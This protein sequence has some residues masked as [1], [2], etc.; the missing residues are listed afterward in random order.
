MAPVAT[1]TAEIS[2]AAPGVESKKVAGINAAADPPSAYTKDTAILHRTPFQ[3][4]TAVSAEGLYF[5][6]ADGTRIIDAVG[7]AAVT[8]IGNGNPVVKQAIKDQVEKLSPVP[9]M[10]RSNEP[11]E[12]LAKLL[13]EYAPGAFEQ[14]AFVAGGSEAMEAVIKLA[15]QYFWETKQ[16]QRTKFISRQ[17][18]YH[19]NTLGALSLSGHPGRRKVFEGILN[20]DS[21][22]HVSP[23]YAARFKTPGETDEEYVARLAKE[24]EDKF[25]ELGPDTV[26]G[27]VAETVVGATTGCVAAPKGYFPAMKAVCEKH[28]ALFILDEVMSGM[29]RMGT[30]MHAWQ[31]YGDNVAPDIQ[32]IAKGLGGGYVSIGAVLMSPRVAKGIREGSG[33]FFHGHT[34]QAHPTTAAGSLAVQ[35]VI[36]E[37]DLLK[38]AAEAGEYLSSQLRATLR[39]PSSIVAP[40]IFDIRGGGA[41]W[42]IEFD[43]GEKQTPKPFGAL[44]QAKTMQK[45]LIVIA[46][47]G[48]LDGGKGDYVILAPP[49]NVTKEEM[50][51]I[52]K[53][54]NESLEELVRE[55]LV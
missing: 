29:G 53:R 28:G 4:P 51:E 26:I 42:G 10:G 20:H 9:N 33:Y 55:Y 40:Y 38:K 13:L 31:T 46:M 22:H 35:K 2:T 39:S 50:D 36:R 30:T 11:A 49:Y 16:P 41:F 34:Y 21:F 43:L 54:L 1:R 14:V 5:T 27:F 44:V 3:P 52:V 12:E 19:G 23:A 7:G 24:L 18:S 25:Q 8:C 37:N 6:L 15:R 47:A 32:A 17:L 48:S 45:G